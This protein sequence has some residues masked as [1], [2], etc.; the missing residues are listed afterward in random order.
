MDLSIIIINYKSANHVLA[1]IQ[2]IYNE[3]QKYIFEIIVVDNNSED[4]SE[5]KI[6]RA[7]PDVTWIQSGYNGGFA[8]ANNIG[9]REAKGNYILVLNAD[10]LVLE[11][12]LDKTIDLCKTKADAVACGVQLLNPDGTHQISGAYF[13]KGGLNVLLPLPYLGRFIRFM[14]YKLKTKIPSVK[15][16]SAEQEVDWIVGAFI[17]VKK[18]VLEKSGLFDEDFF[19]YAEEIEW[20][21]RLGKHGKL[22]LFEKPKVVHIGGGTSSDYYNT[23]NDNS[24]NLWSKKARQII[25]STLLRIRKQFGVFY[26]LLVCFFFIIEIP[27]FVIGLLI[28]KIIKGK[29]AKYKW[30]NVSGYIKNAGYI[31]K[32]FFRILLNKPFFYKVY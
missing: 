24:K 5:S 28:E 4:E 10:T 8:R 23:D 27:V 13:K 19:M 29:N 7:F 30:A 16:V 18:D 31:I 21:S 25:I 2:S 6:R 26:Y 22:Y 32:Y 1:C 11:N 12:A 15:S 3:T 17:M 20:C 14:G 9:I